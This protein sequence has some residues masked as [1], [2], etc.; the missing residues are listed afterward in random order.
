M[1]V[2]CLQQISLWHLCTVFRSSDKY[3]LIQVLM[4]TYYGLTIPHFSYGVVLWSPLGNNY[5]R[6]FS[7]QKKGFKIIAKM[8]FRESCRPAFK[9]LQLCEVSTLLR[10]FTLYV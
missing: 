1:Y 4:V 10:Q 6:A 2:V 8:N 5:L 3:S 9:K 7:L